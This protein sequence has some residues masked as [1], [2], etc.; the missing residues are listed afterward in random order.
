MPAE[1]RGTPD[2]AGTAPERTAARENGALRLS[3]REET[4]DPSDPDPA[5]KT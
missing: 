5:G 2:P 1:R 3:G 4:Q